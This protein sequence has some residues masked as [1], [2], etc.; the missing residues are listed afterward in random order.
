MLRNDSLSVGATFQRY[1]QLILKYNRHEL[2]RWPILPLSGRV[3]I[4]RGSSEIQAPPQL[5]LH[6][7]RRADAGDDRI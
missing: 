5:V 2:S 3:R 7:C 4:C 6:D 1:S